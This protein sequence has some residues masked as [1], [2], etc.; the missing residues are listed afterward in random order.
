MKKVSSLKVIKN[1]F[2]SNIIAIYLDVLFTLNV[3]N[4]FFK[5]LI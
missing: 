2:N 3:N 1:I 4:I 5:A